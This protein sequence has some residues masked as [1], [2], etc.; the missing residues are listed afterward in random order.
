MEEIA[1]NESQKIRKAR[2]FCLT[3]G[4]VQREKLN[5]LTLLRKPGPESDQKC[6]LAVGQ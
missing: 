4:E 1:R 2:V 5:W 6:F 3:R